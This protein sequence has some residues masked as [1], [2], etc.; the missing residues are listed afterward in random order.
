MYRPENWSPQALS[1]DAIDYWCEHP[2]EERARHVAHQLVEA[3]ADAMLEALKSGEGFRCSIGNVDSVQG[4]STTE[5]LSFKIYAKSIV[6]DK[7]GSTFISLPY[8]KP[9]EY[10]PR[11]GWLVFIP[12]EEE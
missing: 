6:E 7:D 5:P 12:D 4:S 2:D 10:P 9:M 11:K 1:K 8:F 3:G